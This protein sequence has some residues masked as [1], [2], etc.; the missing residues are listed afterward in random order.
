MGDVS[1]QKA[2]QMSASA[3]L[4][5][6][7]TNT[8]S[9]AEL[10]LVI[11]DLAAARRAPG[12]TRKQAYDDFVTKNALGIELYQAFAAMARSEPVAG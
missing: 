10:A 5:F 4:A 11:D 3:L 7:R 8:L 12:R 6:V 9:R 2:L 1:V